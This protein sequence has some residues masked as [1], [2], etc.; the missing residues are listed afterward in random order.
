MSSLCKPEMK[1][2]MKRIKAN[3]EKS[4]LILL[5]YEFYVYMEEQGYPNFWD[6]CTGIVY[7]IRDAKNREDLRLYWF[8]KFEDGT[9]AKILLDSENKQFME[10][11]NANKKIKEIQ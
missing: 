10:L 11:R 2:I 8:F 9:E 5:R 1:A 6:I 3:M 7:P 4:R